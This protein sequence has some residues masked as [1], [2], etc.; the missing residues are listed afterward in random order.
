MVGNSNNLKPCSKSYDYQVTEVGTTNSELEHINDLITEVG[1][2]NCY[3]S[4]INALE[5]DV[6]LQASK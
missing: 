5:M 4:A 3:M 1:G 6:S 2:K